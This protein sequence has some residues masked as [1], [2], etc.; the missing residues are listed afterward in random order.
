MPAD[1]L[2]I[3]GIGARTCPTLA[4][5]HMIDG[6]VDRCFNLSVWNIL[7]LG[8]SPIQETFQLPSNPRAILLLDG[9]AGFW[10]RDILHGGY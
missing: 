1:L 10:N 3:S 5:P 2:K 9:V 6:F 7:G 4:V 8:R